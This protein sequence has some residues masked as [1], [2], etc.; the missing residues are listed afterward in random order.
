MLL[1]AQRDE[2]EEW[3]IHNPTEKGNASNRCDG[4]KAI[5]EESLDFAGADTSERLGAVKLRKVQQKTH[6]FFMKTG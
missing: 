6:R 4:P 3:Q 5:G 1:P 2:E